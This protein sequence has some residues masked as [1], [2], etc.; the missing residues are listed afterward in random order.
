MA[1][2]P[3]SY[4][5][6]IQGGIGG[7][8]Y[9]A[10]DI[11]SV[12]ADPAWMN[13]N[14]FR[15][16][17]W[18]DGGVN[19]DTVEELQKNIISE[20]SEISFEMPAYNVALK[21]IYESVLNDPRVV[22][23][24]GMKAGQKVTYDCI[25]FGRYPQSDADGIKT[26]PIKWRVLA[27]HDGVALVMADQN[28]DVWPYSKNSQ[29]QSWE[30][31]YLRAFLNDEFLN[32]AFTSEEKNAIMTMS[33]EN[34]REI[35]DKVS[36]LP[37]E[38]VSNSLYG[39]LEDG[40]IP[41][42]AKIRTNTAYVAAGG[43]LGSS[44]MDGISVGGWWWLRTDNE[45]SEVPRVYGNGIVDLEGYNSQSEHGAICP[46]VSIDLFSIENYSYAG[47]V[48]TDGTEEEAAYK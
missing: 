4:E 26:D 1:A 39:F 8:T 13:T 40:A 30:N 2:V 9:Q 33:Y 43:T 45:T 14:T 20:D 29:G 24:S 28:L 41:D 22:S 46:I 21:A 11:V 16:F 47:T 17:G 5:V 37:K 32:R 34:Q 44:E 19:A 31:S 25:W 3:E 42:E 6:Y 12:T 23:D 36:V 7:G 10:G 18:V 48:C 38:I 35:K 15:F 27:V